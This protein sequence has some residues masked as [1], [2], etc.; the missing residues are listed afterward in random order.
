MPDNQAEKKGL[1]LRCK[2]TTLD[3]LESFEGI[4]FYRCPACHRNFAR[5]AGGALHFRWLH[6]ISL[7]LY[8]VI[9]E[10][11]PMRLCERY[12]AISVEPESTEY[13]KLTIQE[14]SLELDDPTQQIRDILDC[15]ASEDDL[16]KYL[17]CVAEHLKDR[18][19]L[20]PEWKD[21]TP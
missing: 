12:A 17:R 14:I 5:K 16:R 20:A 2:I 15:R 21:H 19:K 6:P 3:A 11:H 1:C 18:L 4:S 7:V 8:P 10:L 9:F 13:L